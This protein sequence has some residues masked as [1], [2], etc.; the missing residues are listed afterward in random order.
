[1]WTV[2][3]W[4]EL[5]PKPS[6]FLHGAGYVACC[7]SGSGA[8]PKSASIISICAFSDNVPEIVR[9]LHNGLITTNNKVRGLR[10]SPPP[11]YCMADTARA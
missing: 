2:S 3:Q 1:M 8:R 10:E 6:V 9:T 4:R 11:A 7:A 5:N